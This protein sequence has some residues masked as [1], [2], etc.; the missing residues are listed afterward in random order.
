LI[1]LGYAEK[2]VFLMTLAVIL[3]FFGIGT[4]R[5]I[6][7]LYV[8][9]RFNGTLSMVSFV[10]SIWSLSRLLTNIP[11]SYTV[12]KFDRSKIILF[13]GFLMG[14]GFF[15][16][17]I[18]VSYYMFLIARFITGCGS[19]FVGTLALATT[20]EI[21]PS[22]KRGKYV[23]I[24][25]IGSRIE[26]IVASVLGGWL[27][28]S[29]GQ[30][31]PFFLGGTVSICGILVLAFL[32][33][34]VDIEIFKDK[35]N[36]QEQINTNI[37]MKKIF[38]NKK[39]LPIYII[40]IVSNFIFNGLIMPLFSVY[41]NEIV[42]L[43]AKQIGLLMSAMGIFAI[44]TIYLGG[45]LTDKLGRKLIYIPSLLISGVG[46][47]A[48]SF[49]FNAIPFAFVTVIRDL[50]QQLSSSI[51]LAYV[52]DNSSDETKT[53]AVSILRTMQDGGGVMGPFILGPIA[54]LMGIKVS[55]IV[56]GLIVICIAW[57]GLLLEKNKKN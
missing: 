11:A 37:T 15:G 51:P 19:A 17:C 13:G 30:I 44:F 21:A 46:T 47:I 2:V 34:Y 3:E 45:Y 32:F 40:A 16:A 28:D 23:S 9:S 25:F 38:M 55:F 10:E 49:T 48:T 36:D 29:F 50:G 18:A 53:Q 39:L 26:N 27:Y 22:N 33:K 42:G 5:P 57:L 52:G 20:I 7:G 35:I 41:A 14:L 12:K 43:S 1:K 4:V 31:T 56:G 24:I 54:D 8:R 6:M